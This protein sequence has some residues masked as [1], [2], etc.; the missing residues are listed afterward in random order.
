MRFK[1]LHVAPSGNL[2]LESTDNNPVANRLQLYYRGKRI[3]EIFDTIGGVGK[4]YYLANVKDAKEYVGKEL[5]G[6]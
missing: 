4:P 6:K 2:V 5:E 3:G 1:A